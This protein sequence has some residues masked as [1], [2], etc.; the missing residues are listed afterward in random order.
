MIHNE[1]D[2]IKH[3]FSNKKYK[4][5]YNA[6]LGIGDDCALITIPK[7]FQLAITTDTLVSGAHFLHN[8]SPEDL[9]CKSLAA[10]LSDLAAMGADP[11][12]IS[13]SISLPKIDENWLKRFS[14]NLFRELNK[15]KIELIGGDITK[16]PMSLTYTAYGLIP[17]GKSLTRSGAQENDLICVTGTLGDSAA[18]LNILQSKLTVKNK[19]DRNWLIKR[20]LR[21]T[22]RIYQGK[23]LRNLATSS[24]DISDGLVSDLKHILEAKQFGAIIRLDLI[25]LSK[26]LQ[27]QVKRKTALKF[28]L[29]GGEDYELCITIPKK[30]YLLNSYFK[31]KKIHLY[32]IGKVTS[33]FKNIR[34]F[35]KNHEVHYRLKLFNHF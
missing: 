11:A 20:H 4:R 17:K 2:I 8:I 27:R 26:K 29:T 6:D 7:K 14:F 34:F 30:K 19:K 12:W 3:Y 1:F 23:I 33:N 22:P 35:N 15:Y 32:C 10:N 9:A 5:K 21:P 16:G 24:I 31:N 25:P 13:L 18:G 28:A